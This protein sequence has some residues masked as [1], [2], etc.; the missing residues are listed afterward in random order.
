MESVP[1]EDIRY[2]KTLG[3]GRLG[4]IFL[5]FSQRFGEVIVKKTTFAGN[6]LI[7]GNFI[8]E[9]EFIGNKSFS[10]I[11]KYYGIIKTDEDCSII[12]EY[13][14]NGFMMDLIE[15]YRLDN[16]LDMMSL[17]KRYQI[18]HDITKGLLQMHSQGVFHGDLSDFSICFNEHW[19]AKI[20]D[21]GL[22][23]LKNQFQTNL[24]NRRD[25]NK[26]FHMRAP[27]TYLPDY[28]LNGKSDVF[29]LGMIFW[30]L[31]NF[32]IPYDGFEENSIQ[33]SICNGDRP[34][35][36]PN[37]HIGFRVLIELCWRHDMKTRP[38]VLELY[39]ILSYIIHEAPENHSFLQDKLLYGTQNENMISDLEDNIFMAAHKGKL[40]SI[41]L[42]VSA[43]VSINSIDK[44]QGYLIKDGHPFIFQHAV[45]I[46][47]SLSIL[48]SM[49][50][51]SMRRIVGFMFVN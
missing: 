50:L 30:E 13:G 27:E 49:E 14:T 43:G 47:A 39:Q 8:R 26:M 23:M 42:L 40:N 31:A 12:M 51:R 44:N 3:R 21:Y 36:P 1:V 7:W 10:N 22:F 46:Q 41:E 48:L 20:S 35:I 16:P 25:D 6:E 15:S 28:K 17:E 34:I 18:A 4:D 32:Q 9:V 24:A 2:I 29:S 19:E 11:T 38:S 37:C 33:Y 45:K 5:A